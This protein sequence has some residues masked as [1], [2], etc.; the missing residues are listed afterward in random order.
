MTT[1]GPGK[2]SQSSTQ[3]ARD[4]LPFVVSAATAAALGDTAA[5]VAAYVADHEELRLE[6]VACS[7]ATTRAGLSHRAVVISDGREGLLDGLLGLAEGVPSAQVVRGVAAPAP[8]PVF[9]F[10]GQGAQWPGMAAELSDRSAVFAESIRAC[11]AALEPY[12]DFELEAVLCGDTGL[13]HVQLVQPALFAV[14]VS[15]AALWRSFGVVPAAVVGHSQGEIVAAHVAGALAVEDGAR[16]VA[17]RSKALAALSGR[18]GMVSVSL[19]AEE[20]NRRFGDR[21]LVAAGD[22]PPMGTL[23][24]VVAAVNAPEMVTLS[25]EHDAVDKVLDQCESDG[26]RARRVRIDYP[27]HSPQVEE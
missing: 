20:A 13:E 18:G 10:S 26:I 7:L 22:A 1:T 16:G 15:L 24:G 5:R 6:D 23:S 17:L 4:A 3:E 9:V 12:V 14:E 2:G 11:A 25:G 8:G 21:L 19:S 27:A